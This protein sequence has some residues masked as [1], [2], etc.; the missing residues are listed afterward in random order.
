MIHTNTHNILYE[1]FCD[2]SEPIR[3]MMFK[4]RKDNYFNPEFYTYLL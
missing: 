4:A 1:I 3:G 2:F